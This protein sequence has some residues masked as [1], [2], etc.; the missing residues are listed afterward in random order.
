MERHSHIILASGSPRRRELLSALL[1]GRD[2]ALTV[3]PNVDVDESHDGPAMDPLC[4]APMLARRKIDAY[5]ATRRPSPTDTVV[6]ADTVVIIDNQVLGKPADADEARRMLRMLS[7]RTHL[8]ATAVA[9]AHDGHIDCSQQV[10]EVT[11]AHLTDVEIDHYISRYQPFD[12][13]GAYGIQEWIGQ[14]GIRSI[15]GDYYNVV[16]LPLRLL[17]NL[18]TR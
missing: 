7:G 5:L 9:V 1:D 14:I 18:L 11:F 10:T 2:I 12:K 13:A 3:D 4:V 16:G 8:V 15:N 17:H 6:T